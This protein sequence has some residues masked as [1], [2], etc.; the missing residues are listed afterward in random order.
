MRRIGFEATTRID[1]NEFGVSWQDEI[2][3][4]GV[5]VSNEIEPILDVDAILPTTSSEPARSSAT[6][7]QLDDLEGPE[8]E[9]VDGAPIAPSRSRFPRHRPAPPASDS[10]PA[11]NRT[12]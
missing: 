3:G 12:E 9:R 4:G 6:D 10:S 11:R 5:V 8:V 1:R 7:A 2:P